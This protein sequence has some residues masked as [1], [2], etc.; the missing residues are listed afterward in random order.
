MGKGMRTDPRESFLASL[1]RDRKGAVTTEYVVLV[2]TIGFAVL[3]ALI[4]V[5]PKLVSDF[6]RA[7]DIT[8]SPIP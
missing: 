5:G 1:I 2:G 7:R 6:T 8:S 3:F 4:T